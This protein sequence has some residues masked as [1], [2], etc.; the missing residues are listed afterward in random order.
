MLKLNIFLTLILLICAL[1]VVAAQHEARKLFVLLER[2]KDYSRELAFELGRLE[3]EQSA[4]ATHLRVESIARQK[5]NMHVPSASRVQV[6]SP[7]RTY[8][9]L[10]QESD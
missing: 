7:D 10:E 9:S 1:G 5:L 3:L 8:Y 6:I 2:E 4:M